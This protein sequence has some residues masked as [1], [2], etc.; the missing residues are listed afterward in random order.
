MDKSHVSMEQHR[1]IVCGKDFDTGNILLDKRLLNTLERHTVTAMGV[2]PE[3]QQYIT[4]G[5]VILIVA[6]DD[7]GEQRTGEICY[8]RETVFSQMFNVPVPS[9]KICFMSPEVFAIIKEMNEHEQHSVA[10]HQE[11]QEPTARS[12]DDHSDGDQRTEGSSGIRDSDLPSE[13]QLLQ[14]H[15]PSEVGGASEFTAAQ[16]RLQ[17]DADQGVSGSDNTPA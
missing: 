7:K 16:A 12:S 13:G 9:K 2:C 10:P 6:I 3:H 4:D 8:I 11:G 14:T 15:G 5:Y 17:R 1:C